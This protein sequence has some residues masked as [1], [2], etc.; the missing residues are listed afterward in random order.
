MLRSVLLLLVLLAGGATA[1]QTNSDFAGPATVEAPEKP[2]APPV[3]LPNQDDS[4]RFAVLGDW[5]TGD[6]SQYEMGEQMAK[7][8]TTFP[9]ELVITTG[10][11]I[12][13]S[14]RPQDMHRKFELPYK[15]LLDREVKFYASLGNHDG[16]EQVGYEPFNMNGD[17]YYSFK[18]PKQNARFFALDSSYP[19]PE[20]LAWIQGEL[21]KSGEDWKIAFFHH[22]LYSSGGRHGSDVTLRQ[23]LEPLFIKYNVSVVFQ[24]HD[25]VYERVEPQNGIAYFVVGAGGKLRAGDLENDSPIM[26]AGFD[27]DL[28][29]LVAEVNGDEMHFQAISRRGAIIDSGLVTRRK[30][31]Q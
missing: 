14:E 11:N 31:P 17:R 16:R 27:R 28:S 7:T 21:E 24:G 25:H 8:H 26:A 18:A 30:P 29:F 2:T 5:G 20:Q 19:E 13:G 1:C 22:P 3:A 15:A 10:D 6:R 12:Y 4:L 9:Y 23:T